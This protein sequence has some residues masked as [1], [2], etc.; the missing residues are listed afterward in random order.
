MTKFTPLVIN[1]VSGAE[2][3]KV[4]K[5]PSSASDTLDSA[6]GL[7]VSAANGSTT[8]ATNLTVGAI[9]ASS[10]GRFTGAF[11]LGSTLGVTGTS[12]IAGLS[13]GFGTFSEIP[14]MAGRGIL[15]N[16][17]AR[18]ETTKTRG[19]LFQLSRL[20]PQESLRLFRTS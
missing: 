20:Y 15:A 8:I 2:R 17:T 4:Q 9:Y 14:P 18:E 13:A 1:S 19:N 16:T 12:T 6:N 5:F 7:T 10:T 11:T 3:G